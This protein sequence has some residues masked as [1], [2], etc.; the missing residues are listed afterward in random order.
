MSERIDA[1]AHIGLPRF[2]TAEQFLAVM[3]RHGIQKAIVAAADTCP[4]IGEVSRAVVEYPQR[5][6]A[7]GVPLGATFAEIS[8]SLRRQA[9]S[10]FLGI[11]IFDR[12]IAEHPH[13]LGVMADLNLIP[14]VVGGPALAP[15]A[16]LLVNFLQAA[17]DRCVVAPHF[18]GATS[19]QVLETPGPVRELFEQPRLL[20]IFSRHGAYDPDLVRGWAA[21]LIEKI[22]CQRILFGSEFPVCLWRNESYQSTLDW[23]RALDPNLDAGAFGGENAYRALWQRPVLAPRQIAAPPL[24]GSGMVNLFTRQGLE[25]PEKIH[26]RLLARYL[27]DSGGDADYRAFITRLLIDAGKE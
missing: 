21:A 16:K 27:A 20:V 17:A 6:R 4:D 1:Y 25:I 22:G 18:G 2:V 8:A 19:P 15:A 24:P 5:F 14:W 13:L 26:Q 12:M 11:R 9:E 23:A 3:D 10:G 7:V